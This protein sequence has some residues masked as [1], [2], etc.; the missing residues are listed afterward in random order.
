MT[1]LD[2]RAVSWAVV[3]TLLLALGCTPKANDEPAADG[4]GPAPHFPGGGPPG[5]GPDPFGPHPEGLLLNDARACSGYTLLAP[6]TSTTTSLI[7][8]DGRTVKMWSSDC[9]PAMSARLLENGHLFRVGALPPGASPFTFSGCGGRV[10]EYDWDGNLVWDFRYFDDN[11]VPHHDAVKLPNGNALLLVCERIPAADARAAGR[12]ADTIGGDY[13]LADGLV[14]IKPTGRTTGE[15][16][17]AWR[18]WDHLVQEHD[19]DKGHYGAVAEHPELI[20]LNLTSG[21]VGFLSAPGA[22]LAKL[23]ALGYVGAAAGAGDGPQAK[24]TDGDWLHLNSVA[25]NPA[26]DQIAVTGLGFSEVWVIDHATTRAEAAGHAGGKRGKG[27]DL[28]YRWGNPRAYRH[29][30]TADQRLVGPH[31]AFWIEPGLPGAGHLLVFNN[32]STRDGVMFS[33]V[34]ELAPPVDRLGNYERAPKA[35]FGP[36]AVVWSYDGGKKPD[37]CSAAFSGAQRLPDGNTLICLGLPGAVVEVTAEGEPVWKYVLPTTPPGFHLPPRPGG[38][39]PGRPGRPPVPPRPGN[40]LF[41]APWYA[42]DYPGLAGKNL[43]PH[44]N[45]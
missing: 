35:P 4:T 20:D 37:F 5:G 8:R 40:P 36:D 6:L 2:R 34:L 33:T 26:L 16:V 23:Q 31:S 13:V 44:P 41:R 38:G 19:R 18:A 12:R 39:P 43:T 7:D 42:P 24:T 11:H 14:E 32:G 1:V 3:A 25:Y 21:R 45:P 17:W 29:G 27:G 15:V 22:D 28:L 30:T 10:Q 9:A